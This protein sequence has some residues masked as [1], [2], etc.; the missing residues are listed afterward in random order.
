VNPYRV[1]I[2][3]L[4]KADL[5]EI[6]SWLKDVAGVEAAVAYLNR[7]QLHI[8]TLENFPQRGTP[9]PK[10]GVGVRSITFERRLIVGYRVMD[11]EVWVERVV[12][13]ARDLDWL[14]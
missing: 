4:A 10:A 12:S 2:R 8:A 7:L 5:L 13:G 3:P 11:H 14:L 1:L 9:R 6:Q